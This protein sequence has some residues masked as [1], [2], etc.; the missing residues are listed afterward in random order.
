MCGDDKAR[1]A[2]LDSFT[3]RVRGTAP[4][5][6]GLRQLGRYIVGVRRKRWHARVV[7]AVHAH[8]T[9]LGAH[10]RA[11]EDE[12]GLAL[13]LLPVARQQRAKVRVQHDVVLEDKPAR[14]ASVDDCLPRRGVRAA[15]PDASVLRLC[16]PVAAVPGHDILDHPLVA[17]WRHVDG[18][19]HADAGELLDGRIVNGLGGVGDD[20]GA[21]QRGARDRGRRCA[22]LG[23]E[24]AE[25]EGCE[26]RRDEDTQLDR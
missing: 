18:V 24:H 3:A 4:S 20:E 16:T 11:E 1:A 22:R 6:H 9:R 13:E 19:V 21:R 25:A 12:V 23:G 8:L 17:H 14:Q 5:Q 2:Q 26:H 10:A 7:V 15:Q